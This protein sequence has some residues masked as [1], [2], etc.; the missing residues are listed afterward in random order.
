METANTVNDQ[1]RLSPV[2]VLGMFVVA[3]LPKLLM[4][5][6]A[7]ADTNGDAKLYGFVAGNILDNFCVSV[8]LPRNGD[9]TPH[10]GGNQLPGYP[11]FIALVW[12]TI[13]RSAEAVLY[14]QSAFFAICVVF[15]ARSLRRARV[16]MVAVW[17]VVILL[18]LSPS[19][20]GWS[21][22]ML[23]ETLS[24]SFAL[25]LLAELVVSFNISRIRPVQ[26]GAILV[27]G[28][29]VR[30]DFALMA[31]PVA[32]AALTIHGP[33][34]ALMKGLV[35]LLVVCI[36]IA[37]WTARSIAL[38]LP[39]TP[40]IGM[41]AKGE[42]LPRGMMNWVA[43]WL[44]NQYDLGRSIWALVHFDYEKFDPPPKAY[45]DAHERRQ[46]E[47]MLEALRSTNNLSPPPSE[48][49]EG[50]E[51]I[52]QI[53]N[54]NTGF[55]E[56]LNLF[57]R[58]G[59]SMWLSPFPSMGWPAE[60]EETNRGKI[61]SAA[62]DLNFTGL[63][64]AMMAAPSATIAKGVV[65]FHRYLL[66]TSCLLLLGWAHRLPPI[67]RKLLWLAVFY[68]GVRTLFFANTLLIET[69]Y[70]VPSLAW[71]D[72]A[73]AISAFTIIHGINSPRKR[74]GDHE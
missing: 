28:F 2:H 71:M 9:C 54:R 51:A 62:S 55:T 25:L 47:K 53:K 67:G 38:D 37:G 60:I 29:F 58:K 48:T 23:T 13:Q 61:R 15:L 36:P 68:A 34:K 45:A 72:V 4:I 59:T 19:L 49:D 32:A 57:L 5:L 10:W 20:V 44:D 16:H 50:F 8:S 11:F 74:N 69:R 33:V 22:S 3:I 63:Y 43:T 17:C 1:H 30:Y 31:F 27:C 14:A 6:I 39:P 18:G 65:S 42:Q 64:E 7:G 41:T 46:V 73:L 21:R 26:L 70:L 12:G 35:V 40:P 24:A 66:L 56:N 52:A